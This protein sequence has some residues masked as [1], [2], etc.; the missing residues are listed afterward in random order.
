MLCVI[1]PVYQ[2]VNA[3]AETLRQLAEYDLPAIIVNDG[4]DAAPSKLIDEIVKEFKVVC[5]THKNNLGKGAAVTSGLFHAKSL[6]FS[7]ALQVDA[8]GQHNLDDV[9]RFVNMME[10]SPD[11]LIAAHPKFDD[12]VPRHRY[13][14]RYAT[15]VWVWINTLSLTIKDSMCG[16]RIYP[17][18]KSCELLS[19]IEM[20]Q[21]MDFDCEFIVRW[22]WSGEGIIQ[23]ES[24]VIYPEDGGSSFQL[25]RDNVLITKM[26]ARLFFGMLLRLPRLLSRHWKN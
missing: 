15:H 18:S 12:S 21:R 26:H 5:V 17:V 19:E 4:S 7:H 22:Y 6:G 3:L 23:L 1:V 20:G 13:Y 10:S 14:G 8:D 24:K 25:V 9:P 16:F 2:H 11:S